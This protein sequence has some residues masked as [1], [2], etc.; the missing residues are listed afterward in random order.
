MQ[1]HFL[2]VDAQRKA[3]DMNIKL[4]LMHYFQQKYNR[5]YTIITLIS[6]CFTVLL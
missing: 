3:Q 2:A 1:M 4:Q 6:P 5:K